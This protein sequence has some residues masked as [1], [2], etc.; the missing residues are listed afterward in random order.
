MTKTSSSLVG[1]PKLVKFFFFFYVCL[2]TVQ[3][4]ATSLYPSGTIEAV[5]VP[6]TDEVL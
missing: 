5:V 3:H 1:W 4:N 2:A 6:A